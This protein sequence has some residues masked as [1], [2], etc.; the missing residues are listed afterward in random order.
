[1]SHSRRLAQAAVDLALEM[2]AGNE[3][4]VAIAAGAGDDVIG[5]DAT[6]IAEEIATVASEK[7]VLVLMDLGSA[8][9]SSELALELLEDPDTI[10]RLSS[11]PFFE[12][13]QAAVVL[14]SAGASLDEV[15]RA[16]VSS[17]D[18]KSTQLR[19]PP[20]QDEPPT[21]G[22]DTGPAPEP[23]ASA[24]ATL[25]NQD[26]LHARPAA[27]VVAT[28]AGFDAQVTIAN[29]H[30]GAGPVSAG[31]P[32][33]L[34]TLD[35]RGSDPVRIEASGPDAQAAVNAV[36]ALIA[37]GFGEEQAAGPAVE[38]DASSDVGTDGGSPKAAPA[39]TARQTQP[40]RSARQASAGPVGVSPGRVVGPALVLP[41]P[42][43]EPDPNRVLATQ[44]RQAAADRADAA[45]D[46]V[47]VAL[48]EQASHV[49]AEARD[50]LEAIAAIAG[51]PALRASLRSG[52]L[53]RGRTPERSVWEAIAS[54]RA[55]YEAGGSRLAARVADLVAVR[56]RIMAQLAGQRA[57][58]I[59]DQ[60]NPYVLVA[61]DLAPT[62]TAVLD[63]ARCLAIVTRE[64]G[65]TSHTAILARSL[66]IPAVVAAEE[67]G[68]IRNGAMLLVDGATGEVIT[69]PSDQQRADVA[70][71][72]HAHAAPGPGATADGHRIPLLA[73][74]GS[75]DD[76]AAAHASGAEGVGL[77][78]TEFCFLDRAEAPSVDEQV[79]AYRRVFDG[80]AG[81]KVVIRTL[82]A[83]ADKPLPF[84]TAS[85][86]PN[87][88]LGVRGYRTALTH[89]ELLDDQ[90]NAIAQAADLASAQVW[91]MAPM[92]STIGEASA[93]ASQCAE[94]GLTQVG[95]MIETPA[96]ALMAKEILATV[97]FV[98]LGTNDL[99]QYTMA[100][101]RTLG[102]LA[103]FNDPWQPSVL[104][105]VRA[106]CTAGTA[107]GKP[108]GV[109]GEAAADP[110]LATVLVG[111]GVTS[112]SMT[113]RARSAVSNRLRTVSSIDICR[114]VAE[115]A[116]AAATPVAARSAAAAGMPRG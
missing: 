74:L 33:G 34:A 15:E 114:S 111:L 2:V 19:H 18:A 113:P 8:I 91:V 89:P 81:Q 82:D 70:A 29:L 107:V 101:D 108:V 92:I 66:G 96:A 83:G 109:C 24:D 105:L 48:R 28:V 60:N 67:A 43:T 95:V 4:P 30:S 73:N 110:L 13:L 103:L 20:P 80:F 63:P 65:P 102:S 52:I 78:R 75:G 88:A 100:A 90:L 71:G 49:A 21:D 112:L 44:D 84:V 115:A 46:S 5:T 17:L 47:G 1:M 31:S 32:T 9:L 3:P 104:R 69:D 87:P 85:G 57:P 16:A 11:A 98:S 76:L 6:R 50:I 99:A 79:T 77:F 61:T 62:D 22:P 38:A 10:V 37:N 51:D 39:Q 54:I 68:T 25:V 64:G 27:A 45:A 93:F 106:V 59:P 53:D 35:A 56:D 94:H 116:C 23:D 36:L 12:G 55:Q 86:E 58:G 26:G 41:P 7:G 72:D 97:D 42:A 40:R 14:A